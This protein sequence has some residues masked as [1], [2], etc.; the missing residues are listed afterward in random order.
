MREAE[1]R[2]REDEGF[3][4]IKL[5]VR[6][7]DYNS[8]PSE[9]NMKSKIMRTFANPRKSWAFLMVRH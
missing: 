9:G 8:C 7:T 4:N 5:T 2:E 1:E 3:E 6:E